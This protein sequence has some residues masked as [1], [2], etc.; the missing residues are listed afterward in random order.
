MHFLPGILS[1]GPITFPRWF[2]W[3]QPLGPREEEE[4]RDR[5]GSGC[6]Q[7]QEC[8]AGAG[9]PISST[10]THVSSWGV[11]TGNSAPISQIDTRGAAKCSSKPYKCPALACMVWGAPPPAAPAQHPQLEGAAD[12]SPRPSPPLPAPIHLPDMLPRPSP[13]VTPPG[14]LPCC[15]K[16]GTSLPRPPNRW[17]AQGTSVQPAGG[18]CAS[19][20]HA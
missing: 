1:C 16:S 10:S 13:A 3:Q 12:P 15:P 14:G 20:E 4:E 9:T 6:P 2:P 18:T 11:S 5:R 8:K 7:P 19:A 17:G